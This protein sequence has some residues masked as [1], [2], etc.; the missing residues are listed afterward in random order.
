LYPKPS[1][2]WSCSYSSS[3]N[4]HCHNHSRFLS[5]LHVPKPCQSIPSHLVH[6]R[7]YLNTTYFLHTY[8]FPILSYL[9]TPLI[10]LR[11]KHFHF[12]NT[13]TLFHSTVNYPTLRIVK[14]SKFHH[15]P[16]LNLSFSFI[17]ILLSHKS[18]D[19]FLR[20]IQLHLLLCFNPPHL[21][22]ES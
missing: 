6:Y 22:K 9:V 14:Y 19:T 21:Q 20:F 15:T 10:H 12:C 4:V 2:F 7:R 18:S 3:F 16:L 13:H 17:V 5:P 11:P 8:A 1:L